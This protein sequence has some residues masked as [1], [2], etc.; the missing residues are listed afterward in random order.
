M[1]PAAA[2]ALQGVL[3]LLCM[4][5]GN[6][7]ELIEFASF[8]IW[9]FYGLAAVALVIMRQTKADVHRPYRVPTIVPWLVII[10][11]LFLS[12]MPIIHDPSPKYLFILAFILAGWMVYHQY[13]FNKTKSR[14]MSEYY[15]QLFNF[16]DY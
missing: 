14:F 16:L 13:V 8:L 11:A 2:V 7:I 15:F 4:V 9:A 3:T 10:I 1:T 5:M 6:I 12:V